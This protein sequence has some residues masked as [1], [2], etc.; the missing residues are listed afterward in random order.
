MTR[1]HIDLDK[2]NDMLYVMKDGVDDKGIINKDATNF[3][4]VSLDEKKHVVGFIST[5]ISRHHSFL[6]KLTRSE[7]RRW[8][9]D[10]L[11]NFNGVA[12]VMA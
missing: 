7:L 6:Y 4:V 9:Q 10:E 11:A 3:L 8:A 5:Y 12:A 1:V 2:T